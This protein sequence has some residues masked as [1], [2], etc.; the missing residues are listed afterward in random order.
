MIR[1]GLENDGTYAIRT[2]SFRVGP[3]KHVTR[4]DD[5][6]VP[7]PVS[8]ARTPNNTVQNLQMLTKSKKRHTK[9]RIPQ[10]I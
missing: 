5:S 8:P 10:N 2:F 4:L 9:M 1:V 6:H 3:G 7:L